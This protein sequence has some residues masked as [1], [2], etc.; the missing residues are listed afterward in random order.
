SE[1]EKAGGNPVMWKTGH[2]HIKSKMIELE[3]PF[4]GE[5]SAHLFFAD[6]YYGYDDA[7]YAA[8]RVLNIIAEEGIS[9][10]EFRKSLPKA[11]NTPEMRFECDET[12]KFAVVDEVAERLAAEKADVVSVDGVRVNT[13]DGWWLL[14][15]SNTQAVLVARCE[16]STDEGL[17][18]LKDQLASQLAKSQVEMPTSF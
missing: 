6:R 18:R 12:R 4:A 10:A 16:A 13:D 14:R 2:S 8:V 7:L 11:V 5:M 9:L 1:V 3:A 15:A 17:Q